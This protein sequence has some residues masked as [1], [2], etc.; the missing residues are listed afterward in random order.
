MERKTELLRNIAFTAH[1]GS[2]KT[3]LAEAVLFNGKATTRLGKVDDGTSHLNYEPEE[4]KRGI[5]ISTAVHHCAWKKQIINLL[6]TPGDYN[7]ISE[8]RFA[9]QAADAAVVVVDA[10]SGVKVG[11][12]KV[13]EFIDENALPRLVFVNKL[14]RERSDFYR[15]VEDVATTFQIKATPVVIPIGAEENFEGVL[16]LVKMKACL[17]SKDGSGKFQSGPVPPEMEEI[18]TEWREKMIENIVEA[19]DELMEKYLEGEELTDEEIETT[20]IQ[21]IKSGAIVPIMC[22][23]AT[24]NIG[25][26]HMMDLVV[27]AFPS[28]AERKPRKGFKPGSDEEIELP[29]DENAPFSGLVFKTIADPF[30][31]K[32]NL[33]RIFSGRLESDSTVYDSTKE[34]KEK[35]GQLFLIEGKKQQPLESAG[36][37]DIVAIPKLKETVTG[38]TL[39][40]TGS[41][42]VY[43]SVQPMPPVISY[44]VEAKVKGTE[45]KVFSSLSRLLDE[46]PTLRLGRDQ[47]SSEIIISGTGQIHLEA[48]CEKLS[49]KFSVEVALNPV[50]VPYRETIKKEVK[51]A[52]YRHKKQTG[53][54]GQFAEVH[55][56]VS[57]LER[58]E[59]F[60]F[61]EALVGMN[62]PRNFVPAVEKGIVEALPQGFL[63]GY[64][65]VDLKVRFYDGKSHDVDS[66]EMAFKIAASMCLKK[67]IQ[68]ANPTLLE[69]IMK[70]E[71]I[72]PEEVMGDVMGDLNGRRGRVLGMDSMGKSQTILAN[73]PMAEVLKYALDLNSMTAGR[74]FFKMEHSHYEEVPAQLAEKIIAAAADK[75]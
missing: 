59:G 28:P 64:P 21:G 2:G 14:D 6:D 70:M 33:V 27:Q 67:A 13:W 29:A 74:G 17:Y 75:E 34:A 42:I 30:A 55:F 10:T 48:T 50:K 51:G 9:L 53:G 57:P 1:A 65:L 31:G 46:D 73:V 63:A 62:V 20:L 32:L 7:F 11:T 61:D 37:G 5:T 16:D 8:A 25:V 66:S 52:I 72:V 12:E 24:L 45:D 49:R 15:T 56:D 18:A 68:E 41:P 44:A 39:C 22:G 69:P 71:I 58:D 36:P 4:I 19:D 43:P 26:P 38:D 3:S 35:F 23:S 40:S 54:R 60:V 47:S